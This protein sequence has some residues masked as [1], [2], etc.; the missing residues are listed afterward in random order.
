MF[1]LKFIY[2]LVFIVFYNLSSAQTII[3]PNIGIRYRD[4]GFSNLGNP[5]NI[6]RPHLNGFLGVEI[7]QNITNNI[8]FSLDSDIDFL[9]YVT[10]RFPTFGDPYR[11]YIQGFRM[12]ILSFLA[13]ATVVF[14]HP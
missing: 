1:K 7:I 8:S 14:K 12:G 6:L 13:I 3:N 4:L 9:P 11:L 10:R 2:T 5:Y